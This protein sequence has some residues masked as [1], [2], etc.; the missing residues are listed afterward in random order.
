MSNAESLV[1][2]NYRRNNILGNMDKLYTVDKF[3]HISWHFP[4]SLSLKPLKV[5]E[6]GYVFL[7]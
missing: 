4:S 6:A 7:R 2:K 3:M 5:L 1:G